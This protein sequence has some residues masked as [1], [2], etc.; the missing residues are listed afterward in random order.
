MYLSG[1]PVCLWGDSLETI[2]IKLLRSFPIAK[3]HQELLSFCLNPKKI[4]LENMPNEIRSLIEIIK[5]DQIGQNFLK[6]FKSIL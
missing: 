3:S 1:I 2:D 6:L 4:P 5:N